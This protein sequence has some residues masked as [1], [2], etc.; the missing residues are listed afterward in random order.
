MA[1]QDVKITMTFEYDP[2]E[3][4][5]KPEHIF[6]FQL[7]NQLNRVVPIKAITYKGKLKTFADPEK[8]IPKVALRKVD[9]VNDSDLPVPPPWLKDRTI[10]SPS[11]RA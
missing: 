7:L 5:G 3:N 4:D 9:S 10:L 1:K 11:V 8:D 6:L 2:E